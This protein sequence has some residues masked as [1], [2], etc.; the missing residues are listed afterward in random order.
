[1]HL[2]LVIPAYNEADRLPE[3]LEKVV[4]YLD[5]Q[6]YD[7]EICIIDDG[8]LDATCEVVLRYTNSEKTAVHLESL[9]KNR[10]K[11]A[12]VRKGM[13]DC[14]AGVY[15]VFYD[16]D[17]STP[18][19]ELEKLWPAFDAGAE[20]VI[21]SRALLESDVQVHQS[22]VREHMGK[23]NNLVLR[24]LGITH[25]SDTQCGFKGFTA[26]ACAEIFPRQTIERFS[27]DAELLYIAERHGLK[28][29]DVPVRWVNHPESRLNAVTDSVRMVLDLL[30]IRLK[31]LMGSYR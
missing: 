3:T 8:S 31:G 14:A 20:V 5:R 27:F 12:A 6:D 15:R 17:G 11:G 30:T 25:F 10:G 18:I 16:A 23:I 21:G 2:S 28:V 7:A 9:R 1:M 24:C 19:E 29:V 22:W 26:T 13:L 4:A